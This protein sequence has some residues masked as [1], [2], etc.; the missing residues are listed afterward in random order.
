MSKPAIDEAETLC[1]EA[2]RAAANAYAPYSKFRV[3]AAVLAADDTIHIGGN[4]ENASF[5]ATV[6]AERVALGTAV[7]QGAVEGI[8]ALALY[9]ESDDGP[10]S[11]SRLVPCGI[12]LQWLA[13][14]APDAS[15]IV[16]DGDRKLTYAVGDLIAKPFTPLGDS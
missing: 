4:V 11:S 3:G 10:F 1:S 6:C 13:E 7:A 12:C 8:R 15:I 5:G 14:L 2:R 16:C 9:A